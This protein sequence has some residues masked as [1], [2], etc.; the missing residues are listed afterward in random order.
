MATNEMKFFKKGL[1]DVSN[2][3]IVSRQKTDHT[4]IG[5][6]ELS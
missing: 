6:L 4:L 2:A 3:S 1:N 5:V